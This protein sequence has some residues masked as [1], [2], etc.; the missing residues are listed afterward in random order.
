MDIKKLRLSE[1]LIY[2]TVRIEYIGDDDKLHMGTGF[3]L[4]YKEFP[5]YHVIV[6]NRHVAQKS[7]S[8]GFSFNVSDHDGN[9]LVSRKLPF[10][11]DQFF[12]RWYYHK[13]PTV[14]LAIMPIG[15]IF[16]DWIA[17]GI[18]TFATQINSSTIPSEEEWKNY[19]ALEDILIIG[20]PDMIMDT[21]N[22]L[23]LCVRGNTATHPSLDYD[24]KKEFVVSAGVYHGSS[25][26]PVFL[27][28]RNF[29]ERSENFQEGPD[30]A[31]LLGIIYAGFMHEVES[32]IYSKIQGFP[33]INIT[34]KDQIIVTR[35]PMGVSLAIKST[36]LNDFLP[37]LSENINKLEK[38]ERLE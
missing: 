19:H 32:R 1:K 20:Y 5:G 33:A 21:H 4:E 3:I 36:C 28:D 29:F 27:I 35:I 23:P 13:D 17:Q 26:S 24:S 30:R 14:D 7:K 25:G 18:K 11:A 31:R 2:S 34:P 9:L 22:N 10:V 15:K 37:K 6:S 16:N 12:D 8:G 38:D